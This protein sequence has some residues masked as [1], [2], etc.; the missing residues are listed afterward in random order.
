[1][2]YTPDQYILWEKG[3]FNL[4]LTL[5]Y[6][7]AVMIF[8]ILLS[9]IV[10]RKLS[11]GKKIS[12]LQNLLEAIVDGIDT[13]VRDMSENNVQHLM[14]LAGTLFIFILVSNLISLI[15]GVIAPTASMSTTA[16]LAIFVFISMMF[17][18]M[19]KKGILGYFKKYL[20]PMPFLLRLNIISDISGNFALAVRLYGNMMSGVVISAVML[21]IMFLAW[22]FPVF[23]QLLGLISAVIQAYIFSVLAMIFIISA[24]SD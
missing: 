19:K 9:V 4:N 7:W 12:K 21:K 1:M 16:A 15:P 14:P 13:Q 2:K 10:T 17:Y 5:V 3:I 18:G 6:T 24:E 8:I 20:K 22:G 11:S 23:I